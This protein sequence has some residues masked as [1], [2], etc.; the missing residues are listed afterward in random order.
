MGF[1]FSN[2]MLSLAESVAL[3]PSLGLKIACFTSILDSSWTPLSDG[4]ER[5]YPTDFCGSKIAF[6]TKIYD[7]YTSPDGTWQAAMKI[8][9]VTAN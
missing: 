8:S 5:F 7:V 6:V 2:Q 1:E 4:E 9:A 3:I